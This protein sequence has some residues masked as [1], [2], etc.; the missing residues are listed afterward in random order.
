MVLISRAGKIMK[1]LPQPREPVT[2]AVDPTTGNLAVTIAYQGSGGEVLVYP[3]ASGTPASYTNPNVSLYQFAGYD[4][5]GNLFVDGY[6]SSVGNFILLELP[7]SGGS[8]RT[9]PVSGMINYPGSLQWYA[10]G[11][12]LAVGDGPCFNSSQLNDCVEWVS[13][14]GTTGTIVGATGLLNSSG[15]P[16]CVVYQHVLTPD[17]AMRIAGTAYATSCYG[18][19]PNSA[20][21]W[22]YPTGGIP[23]SANS[24]VKFSVPVG[25]AISSK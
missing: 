3:N 14:S 2:C 16:A 20:Y 9:I 15:G 11:N 12:Y 21:L 24:S 19:G 7:Y 23:T 1:L 18:Y 17:K 8:L 22:S 4:P 6:D 5:G 10:P 13:I 25:A